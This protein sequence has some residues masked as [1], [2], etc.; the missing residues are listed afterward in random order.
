MRNERAAPG[1]G[2][3]VRA[4]ASGLIG[5]LLLMGSHPLIVLSLLRAPS[6]QSQST[7]RYKGQ[8]RTEPSTPELHTDK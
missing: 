7:G 4:A 2:G 6:H 1:G 3:A 5:V 8:S